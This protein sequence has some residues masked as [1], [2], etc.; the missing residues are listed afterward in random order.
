MSNTSTKY[1]K[2]A[3]KIARS[4]AVE[5]RPVPA[6]ITWKTILHFDRNYVLSRST[7]VKVYAPI[8]EG[9]SSPC[10]ALKMRGKKP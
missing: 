3:T 4:F 7:L 1:P 5:D 10:I 2:A 6:R 9:A 8:R